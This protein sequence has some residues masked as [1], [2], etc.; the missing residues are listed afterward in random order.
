MTTKSTIKIPE[1]INLTSSSIKKIGEYKIYGQVGKGSFGL[2]LLGKKTSSKKFVVLKLPIRSTAQQNKET[3][4]EIRFLYHPVYKKNCKNFYCLNETL[5]LK[6]KRKVI[7]LDLLDGLHLEKIIRPRKIENYKLTS[8]LT[9]KEKAAFINKLIKSL[10]KNLQA[11]HKLGLSHG[12]I[13]TGNVMYMPAEKKTIVVDFGMSCQNINRGYFATCNDGFLT[14]NPFFQT[15]KKRNAETEMYK[16]FNTLKTHQSDDIF[17]L[18]N[19]ITV[20][21]SIESPIFKDVISNVP[22]IKKWERLFPFEVILDEKKRLKV[23]Q[24]FK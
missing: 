20:E 9:K 14:G 17:A 5:E 23:F 6:D 1:F 19:I 21:I 22:I 16:N 3:E 8:G 13:H 2:I 24:N 4:D 15:K 10:I 18:N 11:F 12:D 7:V